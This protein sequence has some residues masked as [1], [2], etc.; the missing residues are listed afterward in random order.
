MQEAWTILDRQPDP[1]L[2]FD[3]Q[4]HAVRFQNRAAARLAGQ[5]AAA[6]VPLADLRGWLR[7]SAAKVATL[8]ETMD[9]ESAPKHLE[10]SHCDA[11]F[12]V[13]VQLPGSS[14]F[15]DQIVAAFHDI[16]ERRNAE[17]QKQELVSTVSHELRSPLTAIKGAMG[18]V[19]AGS[20]G[21]LPE[22]AR[23]MVQIAH[24][25]ADRLILIINDILDLD[26]IADGAMVFDNAHT[27]LVEVIDA[28]VEA[29]AGYRQ[30]FDVK[31]DLVI[32]ARDAVAFIDPNR[33]VQVLVNLLSNAIKFSPA[34]AAVTVRLQD[35]GAFNRI[36]V[37]DR[38]EGIPASEQRFLFDRFVQIGTRNRA[39]TGGT[40][41]G[42][43]IVQAI[44]D[45]QNGHI[46][47]T[48][49]V[50]VG[51]T[52]HVDLPKP[53]AVPDSDISKAG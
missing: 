9:A 12:D 46:T 34:G 28:A 15:P 6:G 18:L 49:Q 32:E 47:F 29:V 53:D 42:L 4:T 38:G 16:T 27:P 45:K 25:N 52:F 41:L 44:L 20:A 10:V 22:R 7:M 33:L 30:R 17:R 43:S 8:L 3:G 13:T 5:S 39:A 11:H 19:L 40:G 50:G 23:D 37:T 26:K 51:T 1:V 24:R 21:A 14:G 31:A 36:S 48:S 35:N 2:V